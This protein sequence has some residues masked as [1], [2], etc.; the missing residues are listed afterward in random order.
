MALIQPSFF[1]LKWNL[2]LKYSFWPKNGGEES[3]LKNIYEIPPPCIVVTEFVV[4]SKN[5]PKYHEVRK[6]DFRHGGISRIFLL[7][8]FSKPFLHQKL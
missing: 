7:D 4:L 6:N 2:C 3:G 1:P 8:H 5:L